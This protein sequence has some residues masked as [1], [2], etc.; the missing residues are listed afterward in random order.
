MSED[1]VSRMNRRELPCPVCAAGDGEPHTFECVAGRYG[2][3]AACEWAAA[4][5][6]DGSYESPRP[7]AEY[8][9][10]MRKYLEV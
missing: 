6:W 2:V 4:G 1:R 10:R 9:A 5:V 8:A 7:G 3:D